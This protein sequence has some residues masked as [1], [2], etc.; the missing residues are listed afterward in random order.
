MNIPQ[1]N[2]KIKIMITDDSFVIRSVLKKIIAGVQDIEIVGLYSSA[3]QLLTALDT[4]PVDILL[5]DI[6]MPGMTGIEAIP[7]ILK[8]NSKVKI[9]MVS[10]LTKRNAPIAIEALTLGAVDYIEKPDSS[11]IAN[12]SSFQENLIAKIKNIAC[13]NCNTYVS[14]PLSSNKDFINSSSSEISNFKLSSNNIILRTDRPINFEPKVFAIASST[15]GPKA[16]NDLLICFGKDYLANKIILVTQHMPILFTKLLAENLDRLDIIKCQEASD[17]DVLTPGNLY[18]APGNKH[19]KITLNVNK[20]PSI[21]LD[22]GPTVNFCKPS[23]DPMIESAAE[24]FKNEM[25][26]IVL[27]GMGKDALQGSK[28]AVNLGCSIIAQDETSSIVWGM[29]GNVALSNLCSAVLPLN[30]IADFIKKKGAI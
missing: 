6:E 1:A 13:S 2:H 20:K 16:I 25:I 24:I 19:M 14:K 29:P 28:T 26:T 17:S 22:D 3:E 15:G 5:L 12:G 21:V 4:L 9:F 30:K 23:A 11:T 8:K 18:L 7:H 27:T 10:T